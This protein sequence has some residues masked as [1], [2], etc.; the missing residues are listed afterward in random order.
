MAKDQRC[1]TV[2]LTGRQSCGLMNRSWWCM[3][4]DQRCPPGNLPGRQS[5]GLMNRSWWCMA[6]DQRCPTVK[7]TGRQSCGLMNRSLSW[8]DRESDSHWRLQRLLGSLAMGLSMNYSKSQTWLRTNDAL[9]ATCREGSR[10]A[11]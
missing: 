5:C 11:L 1:P 9:L 3:A 8:Q 10:V 4:K 7:L 6:K 2:K